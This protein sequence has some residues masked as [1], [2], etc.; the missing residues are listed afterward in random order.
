MYASKRFAQFVDQLDR[1]GREI[2]DEIERVF[3]L[4]GYSGGQLAERSKLFRLHQA[5]LRGAQIFERLAQLL[6]SHLNVVKQ[7]HILDRDHRLVGKGGQQFDLLVGERPN[8][9]PHQ[10]KYANRH[11]LPQ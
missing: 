10:Y 6:G 2:I 8:A 1:D 9:S 7:A 11:A 4:V 5:V 3:D